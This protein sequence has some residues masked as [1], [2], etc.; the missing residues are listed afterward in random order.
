M[1]NGS[2]RFGLTQLCSDE[3]QLAVQVCCDT[4]LI[5]KERLTAALPIK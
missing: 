4:A 2:S 1:K 3:W 5:V